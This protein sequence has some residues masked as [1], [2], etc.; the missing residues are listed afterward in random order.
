MF[1]RSISLITTV[2]LIAAI[3]LVAQ[4]PAS[5]PVAS[6]QVAQLRVLAPHHDPVILTV[7]HLKAMPHTTVIIHNTH[8][9]VHETYSGIRLADLLA[10][11]GAPLGN[12]LR[13]KALAQY[14]VAT[15]SDGYQTVLALGEVDPAFHPGEVLVVDTMDGKSLD[16]HSGPLQLVVTEDKHPARSVRN[17][18]QIELKVVQ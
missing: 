11:V 5:T 7:T 1:T 9:N 4:Q 18:I 10:K 16:T 13:G 12:D 2:Y 15:G 8:A 14:I 17:L 3:G 6:A